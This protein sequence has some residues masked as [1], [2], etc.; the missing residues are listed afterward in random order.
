MEFC[1]IKETVT[2]LPHCIAVRNHCFRNWKK[3]HRNIDCRSDCR[4][5]ANNKRLKKELKDN[6]L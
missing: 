6:T 3:L 4:A 1:I 5:R 2:E